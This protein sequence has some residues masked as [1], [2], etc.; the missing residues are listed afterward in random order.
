MRAR[1]GS[2]SRRHEIGTASDPV[3]GSTPAVPGR[4]QLYPAQ[5]LERERKMV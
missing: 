3:W 1:C 2:G 4:K 5:D